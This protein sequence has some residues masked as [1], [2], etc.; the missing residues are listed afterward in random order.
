LQTFGDSRKARFARL[1]LRH[2]A[3]RFAAAAENKGK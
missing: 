1:S 3:R 2:R